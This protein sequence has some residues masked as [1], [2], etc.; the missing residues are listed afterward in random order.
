MKKIKFVWLTPIV[1]VVFLI[2]VAQLNL[3]TF[4]LD[5]TLDGDV[6]VFIGDDQPVLGR[7]FNRN[8]EAIRWYPG[9][10]Q[11]NSIFLKNLSNNNV[12][13]NWAKVAITGIYAMNSDGSKGASRDELSDKV[14][15]QYAIKISDGTKIY[16]EGL[17]KD[18]VA[19]QRINEV[20]AGNA[21]DR[22]LDVDLRLLETADND[23]ENLVIDLNFEFDFDEI[24]VSAS[25]SGGVTITEV[26]I[27][28][29][30]I[31][32]GTIPHWVDEAMDYLYDIDVLTVI[33]GSPVPDDLINRAEAGA[34]VVRLLGYEAGETLAY[35][36]TYLDTL[37]TYS[38]DYIMRGTELGVLEGYPDDYYRP[39]DLVTRE[40]FA[41]MIDRAFGLEGDVTSLT[42]Y[43]DYDSF[44]DTWGLDYLAG[45][46]VMGYYIGYEDQTLKPKNH[47]SNAECYT[48]LYRI[49]K[50]MEGDE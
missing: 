13:L 25:P 5:E 12:R 24:I 27:F 49:A 2:V 38:H 6:T 48:V 39:Y 11:G 35:E 42:Y 3:F 44:K 26:D 16:F 22:V 10:S 23:L 37:P 50:E 43:K 14:A 20:I 28:D 4:A 45:M 17:L 31:A 1:A 18:F 36:N 15:E 46:D 29:D 19:E 7:L 47:L 41:A 32:F 8:D 34:L 33:P 21:Q 30:E 40:E 9:Y